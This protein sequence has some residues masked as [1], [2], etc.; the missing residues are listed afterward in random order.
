MKSTE[1][2]SLK[3]KNLQVSA[4]IEFNFIEVA[5]VS[6]AICLSTGFFDAPATAPGESEAKSEY[7]DICQSSY[8]RAFQLHLQD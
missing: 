4:R 1:M 7:S 5:A 8:P 2:R 6:E 3:L